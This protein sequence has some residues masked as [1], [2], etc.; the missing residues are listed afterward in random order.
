MDY[1]FVLHHDAVIVVLLDQLIFGS[2]LRSQL[3]DVVNFADD[4]S[5]FLLSIIN[6]W[7]YLFLDTPDLHFQHVCEDTPGWI[8][9]TFVFACLK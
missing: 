6:I 3:F 5:P 4:L 9:E 8:T 7:C 1:F 2:A